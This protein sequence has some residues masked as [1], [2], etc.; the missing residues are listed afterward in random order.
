[1]SNDSSESLRDFI[2]FEN[3]LNV[4]KNELNENEKVQFNES[5]QG[6]IDKLKT[7]DFSTNS[8]Y[9]AD[10]YKLESVEIKD[11]IIQNIVTSFTEY[12]KSFESRRNDSWIYSIYKFIS[13]ISIYK[14]LNIHNDDINNTLSLI[15]TEL[16]KAIKELK[17]K[18]DDRYCKMLLE[19]DN[20]EI[21]DIIGSINSTK[22]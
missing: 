6:F 21:N 1:M 22:K 7:L 13:L 2:S 15:Y 14:Q 9:I 17:I 5:R 12:L 18:L 3:T 11:T 10:L 4:I 20:P 19:I 16:I 8:Y